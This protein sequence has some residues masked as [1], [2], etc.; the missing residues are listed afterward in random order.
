[1][2]IT[3]DFDSSIFRRSWELVGAHQNLNV[4]WL[5][6]FQRYA[7]S[8]RISMLRVKIFRTGLLVT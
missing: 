8:K 2:F 4:T 1:M 6:P 7:E 3:F 5:R